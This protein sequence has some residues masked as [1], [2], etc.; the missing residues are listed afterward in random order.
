MKKTVRQYPL[1][2][3][4]IYRLG[5]R[6]D[7]EELLY[8]QKGDSRRVKCFSEYNI[9]DK[10]KS[11]GGSRTIEAPCSKMKKWQR[12]V[13]DLM[14]RIEKPDWGISATKGKSYKDNASKHRS[15]G[16]VMT[17]DISSF[18]PSCV[19]EY[20]FFARGLNAR[21]MWRSA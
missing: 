10:E 11:S 17:M 19:R 5:R 16:Y 14:A 6:R 21:Q 15:N 12:R 13:W 18:Y 2:R 20:V 3:S 8:M 7:L 9:F 1:Q 4:P